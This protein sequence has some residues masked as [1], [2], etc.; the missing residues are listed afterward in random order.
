MTF[1]EA[2]RQ[3]YVRGCYIKLPDWGKTAWFASKKSYKV[4]SLYMNPNGDIEKEE[5]TPA[6]M[7]MYVDRTDWEASRPPLNKNRKYCWLVNKTCPL[8]KV[9]IQ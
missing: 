4:Y 3:M 6:R 9:Y 1:T 5:V 8:R 7:Q 2:L